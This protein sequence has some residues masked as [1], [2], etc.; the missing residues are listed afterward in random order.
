MSLSHTPGPTHK[1]G[2]RAAVGG[3]A[4]LAL[5]GL[6]PESLPGQD[7]TEFRSSRQAH[8]VAES[9]VLEIVYGVGRLSV[10][11]AEG[12]LLYDVRMR[13]D[14]EQFKPVRQ[15]SLNEGRGQLRVG[16]TTLDDDGDWI[17]AL[18]SGDFDIDPEL[19]L[20]LD[21]LKDFDESAGTL[22]LKL[23][24]RLPVDLKLSAGAVATEIALG[25]VAVSRLELITAASETELSFDDPNPVRM[26]ELVIRAGAAELTAERLGNARFDRF[27]LKG[28]VGDIVLD[29]TGEWDGNATG[30]VKMGLGSLEL[31]IPAE[32]GVWI[33]KSSVL[34]SFSA[35]DLE[36]VDG[37]YRS[38]NWEGAEHK[39]ELD[40]KTAFGTIAVE[41]VP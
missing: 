15:W 38:T 11:P 6:R 14:A 18:A 8:V 4:L 10:E 2:V 1:G 5:I 16:L 39:L 32:I 19:S 26:A 9:F 31:K 40:L 36:K 25:G 17:S 35:P 28:G 33:Q 41:I 27:D 29:F 22:E 30:T 7:W 34:T 37:G 12:D 3:L 21:D 13:Y 20:D 24:R 23:G